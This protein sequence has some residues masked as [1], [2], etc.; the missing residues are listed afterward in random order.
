MDTLWNFEQCEITLPIL[1]NFWNLPTSTW[2]LIMLAVICWIYHIAIDP[3]SSIV[4]N[5][6]VIFCTLNVSFINY[7]RVEIWI[8]RIKLW[9]KKEE[10]VAVRHDLG[11][12]WL[13]GLRSIDRANWDDKCRRY[14]NYN[15]CVQSNC[16]KNTRLGYK[17]KR[18]LISKFILQPGTLH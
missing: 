17:S 6:R 1:C 13:K 8:Y 5:W 12:S 15:E 11:T 10:V 7:L 14:Y 9:K 4:Y 18:N 16:F 2:G 3:A